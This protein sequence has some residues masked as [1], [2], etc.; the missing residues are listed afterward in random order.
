MAIDSTTKR[1]DAA[2]KIQ[3]KGYLVTVRQPQYSGDL[4]T[5]QVDRQVY[6]LLE[7]ETPVKGPGGD[8]VVGVELVFTMAALDSTGA[9][10]TLAK[11]DLVQHGSQWV[12]VT[13]PNAVAP[14]AVPI[15]YEPIVTNRKSQPPMFA[16]SRAVEE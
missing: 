7:S 5:G 13:K 16:K 4:R 2:A 9:P 12:P 14:N 6:A 10:L 15:L 3:A 11:G 8:N 1:L